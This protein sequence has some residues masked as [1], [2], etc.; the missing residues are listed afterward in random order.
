LGTTRNAQAFVFRLIAEACQ[1]LELQLV[2]SLGG[3]FH[4]EMF[5]DLPG[6]PL[7]LDYVPQLELLKVATIVITHCGA[8]TV[9]AALMEGKPMVAIPLAHDQPAVAARLARLGIAE[10]LP[11]MRLSA[12]KIHRAVTRVLNDPGYCDAALKMQAELHSIRGLQRAADIIEETL[13]EHVAARLGSVAQ[14]DLEP[15]NFANASLTPR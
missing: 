2:I 1:D 11:V 3:R 4:P 7:V 5:A 9:F 15:D 10:V 6:K 12:S 13:E 14:Y 8:N